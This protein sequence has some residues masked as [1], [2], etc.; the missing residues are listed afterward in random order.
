VVSWD[1]LLN[2]ISVLIYF[3]SAYKCTIHLTNFSSARTAHPTRTVYFPDE[4][5]TLPLE[6]TCLHDVV[7]RHSSNFLFP[8]D[9]VEPRS[10]CN[11]FRQLC[12]KTLAQRRSCVFLVIRAAAA[13]RGVAFRWDGNLIRA[14]IKGTAEWGAQLPSKP[15]L[16]LDRAWHL[17]NS[18]C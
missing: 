8:S 18:G 7:L 14:E 9:R 4:S 11:P 12:R 10:G 3:L 5:H 6:L 15:Y 2:Q 17:S 1:W 13:R 16:L